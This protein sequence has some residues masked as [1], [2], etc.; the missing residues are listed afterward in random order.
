MTLIRVFVYTLLEQLRVVRSPKY[1]S[2]RHC[3]VIKNT[4]FITAA[5]YSL[6]D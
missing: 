6:F 5:A 4:I 2:I 1:K 3:I